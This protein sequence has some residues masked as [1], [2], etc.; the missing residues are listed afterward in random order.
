[1]TPKTR[2]THSYCGHCIHF[3]EC[4]VVKNTNALVNYCQFN[5]SRFQA[6][7]KK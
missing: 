5:A 2:F 1:M 7:E 6:V 4:Q 3:A